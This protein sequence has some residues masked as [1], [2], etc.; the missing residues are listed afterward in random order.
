MVASKL[1][2]APEAFMLS[3]TIDGWCVVTAR[4]SHRYDYAN[5]AERT[6]DGVILHTTEG[7]VRFV[8]SP[9]LAEAAQARAPLSGSTLASNPKGP[10]VRVTRPRG[11]NG[12]AKIA[13]CRRVIERFASG[14]S[15][16]WAHAC[17]VCGVSVSL[18]NYYARPGCIL[19]EARIR[20]L[21][22]RRFA[23]RQNNKMSG[24]GEVQN[25]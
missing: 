15:S 7:P 19:H 18:L 4:H 10:E 17:A 12:S 14:E 11:T 6:A 22:K 1:S 23:L 21:R 8:C 3:R 5:G 25:G 2:P 24:R 20:A 13:A 9:A 16:S